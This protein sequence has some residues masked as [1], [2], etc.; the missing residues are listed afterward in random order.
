MNFESSGMITGKW[1]NPNNG[2]IINIMDTVI[3]ENNQ[4]MLVTD[5]GTIDMQSFSMNFIQCDEET[6][7][8]LTPSIAPQQTVK[9]QPTTP[10]S[11]AKVEIDKSIEEPPIVSKPAKQDNSSIVEKLFSKIES[12]PNIKIEIDWDDFP[13]DQV[14]MLINFLD[15]KKEDISRYI[16][17][18]YL[19]E[20]SVIIAL[21]KFLEQ[22]IGED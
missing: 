8:E 7:K 15:V 13:I 19:D 3:D 1:I 6:L 18:N 5:K 2:T 17:D 14:N 21:N 16:M 10:V 4:M 12:Q 11:Q 9:Q 20:Y 22:K